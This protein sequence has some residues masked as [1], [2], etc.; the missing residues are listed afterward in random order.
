MSVWQPGEDLEKASKELLA[1]RAQKLCHPL[2]QISQLNFDRVIF[3]RQPSSFGS[4]WRAQLFETDEDASEKIAQHLEELGEFSTGLHSH[5]PLD[6]LDPL[7]F[8]LQRLVGKQWDGKTLRE[9]LGEIYD[10]FLLTQSIFEPRWR[11]V[12]AHWER[13]KIGREVLGLGVD[14]ADRKI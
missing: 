6:D 14:R 5:H 2:Y 4:T 3:W 13:E 11:E 8:A 9:A 10:G 12:L 1:K 7:R